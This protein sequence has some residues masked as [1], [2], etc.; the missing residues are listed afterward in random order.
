[1]YQITKIIHFCYGHRLLNYEGKCSQPHGH[2]GKAE[3]CLESKEL[4]SRGMVCDFSDISK[5]IKHWIDNELD[6]RMLL[7]K[8]DP[9]IE[10]LKVKSEPFH[11]MEDN[12]TAENIAKLIYEH[13]SS[14]GFPIKKVTLWE[15]ESSFAVYQPQ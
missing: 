14:Q 8:D 5:G 9:L 6:H 11:A 12:P 10:W 7:R 2:N 1:M 4:D 15:T 3:I 13:A